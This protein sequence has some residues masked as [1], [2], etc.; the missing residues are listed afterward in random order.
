MSSERNRSRGF[1][2][3][4]MVL[5]IV[6]IGVGL[7]GVLS[8]FVASVRN[9][10]DP[11]AR[12]QLLSIA[13]EMMEEITLK[14]YAVNGAAPAPANCAARTTYD[15]VSDYNGY[16]SSGRICDID[17]VQ[18]ALLDGFSVSVSVVTSTLQLVPV[19]QITV[20][21]TRGSESISLSG[22]RAPYAP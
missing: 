13:E 12:K 18:I 21:A 22:W 15:D 7:A 20:T 5:A 6:I 16:F 8:V 10:A 11:V 9:S 3:V 1:T 19:K 17:G 2:L 4:E 14:P